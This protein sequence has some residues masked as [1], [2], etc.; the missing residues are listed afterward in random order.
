MGDLAGQ[1]PRRPANMVHTEAI[2][3]G[4]AYWMVTPNGDIPRRSPA[5]IPL[6]SS[7]PRAPWRPANPPRRAEEVVRR[8]LHLRQRLPAPKWS[9]TAPKRRTARPTGS[10]TRRSSQGPNP[11]GVVP[12]IP[13]PNNPS[14]LY[15]GAQTWPAGQ[16]AFRTRSRRQS[17]TFSSV[18]ST[19]ASLSGFCSASRPTRPETGKVISV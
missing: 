7:S 12:M 4:E 13:M 11:L 16:S 8:R 9:S 19:T 6:R 1:Q 3:L 14:M 17:P 2:K 10:A 5:S 15:G 18:P